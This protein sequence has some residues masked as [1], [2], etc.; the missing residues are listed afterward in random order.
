[1]NW[2]LN[3][4]AGSYKI[5]YKHRSKYSQLCQS[6][7]VWFELDGLILSQ[8]FF[9]IK[10]LFFTYDNSIKKKNFALKKK[11]IRKE[12]FCIKKEEN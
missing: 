12:E 9:L 3:V 2:D 4:V 6:V 5:K 10:T 8:P 11:K 7:Q 1:M